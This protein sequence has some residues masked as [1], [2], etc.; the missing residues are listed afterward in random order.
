M[1]VG[2]R[3]AEQDEKAG[4]EEEGVRQHGRTRTDESLLHRIRI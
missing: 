3:K 2:S 4:V 1:T